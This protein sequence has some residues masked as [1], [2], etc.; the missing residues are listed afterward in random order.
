MDEE[1]D[2]EQN[3][4]GFDDG[5]GKTKALENHAMLNALANQLADIYGERPVIPE[6]ARA[7]NN[8]PDY[9]V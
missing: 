3:L 9:Y 8:C 1:G 7:E 6:W 5:D 4:V 2:D